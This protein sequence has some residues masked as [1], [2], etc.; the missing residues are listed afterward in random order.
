MAKIHLTCLIDAPIERVFDLS[1][2]IELHT[3]STGRSKE[4]AI[5]GVMKGLINLNESVTWQA[6]HLFKQRSFTSKI[7]AFERPFY[8]KDEMQEGDFKKFSHDHFFKE[9]DGQTAMSDKLMLE[10]PYGLLGRMVTRL[11]LKNYIATFLIERN[12]VIKEYAETEKWR[13][14][15][16]DKNG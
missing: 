5:A 6:K 3:I 9:L 12:K 10:S 16:T 8:F 15:L 2:S 11:F 7:V 13:T 4:K 1:R 14:I